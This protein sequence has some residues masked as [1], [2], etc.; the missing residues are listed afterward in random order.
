MLADDAVTGSLLDIARYA[1]PDG[2]PEDVI[3]TALA[4]ALHGLVYLHQN[5]WIHRD[6]K[7][8]NLLVDGASRAFASSNAAS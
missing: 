1:F 3:A 4:Q 6:I 8:A 2:F 5:G 7:A